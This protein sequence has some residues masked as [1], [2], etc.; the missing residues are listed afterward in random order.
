[1]KRHPEA[2]GVPDASGV[3]PQAVDGSREEESSR[4]GLTMSCS[5]PKGAAFFGREDTPAGASVAGSS[6]KKNVAFRP[7]FEVEGAAARGNISS[8]ISSVRSD[9]LFH[10]D[11]R[12]PLTHP[13]GAGA[14]P[15][16]NGVLRQLTNSSG[17]GDSSASDCDSHKSITAVPVPRSPAAAVAAAAASPLRA[18]SNA[19]AAVA[20][21]ASG[22]SAQGSARSRQQHRLQQQEQQQETLQEGE[23]QQQRWYQ[24]LLAGLVSPFKELAGGEL[25]FAWAYREATALHRHQLSRQSFGAVKNLP[26]RRGA[27]HWSTRLSDAHRTFTSDLQYFPL[28]F[29]D[30]EAE[31]EYVAVTNY[32][33][34]LRF[35]VYLL[36]QHCLLLPVQFS[37]LLWD[38]ES[39]LWSSRAGWLLHP[40]IL[41]FV[42]VTLFGLLLAIALLY[43]HFMPC[44]LGYFCRVHAAQVACVY[45]F[46]VRKTKPQMHACICGS[47]ETHQ[48][49]VSHKQQQK[50][51]RQQ[52]QHLL[53]L[54]LLLSA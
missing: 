46:S 4:G 45:S 39:Q 34:S 47:I 5:L 11:E 22:G 26:S 7:A 51:R 8:L 41:S 25:N 20:A 48:L 38:P 54:S 27:D 2:S 53:L 21:A 12:G 30:T 31:S 19:A 10:A 1:M 44:G 23:E 6:V 16:Y 29:R 37:L 17:G 24:Q 15:V 42:V 9:S 3:R 35:S 40:L 36:L 33:S 43:P 14:A 50:R 18:L 13:E 32:Q 28:Q 49:L 52:Q